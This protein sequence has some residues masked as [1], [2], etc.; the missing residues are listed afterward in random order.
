MNQANQ[1]GPNEY[2]ETKSKS[3]QERAKRRAIMQ[4]EQAKP[5]LDIVWKNNAFYFVMNQ[6][7][8]PRWF[9][10]TDDVDFESK[11]NELRQS[12]KYKAICD[13]LTHK[14]H[15]NRE[16]EKKLDELKA[17][18]DWESL[19]ERQKNRVMKKLDKLSEKAVKA[20]INEQQANSIS[21]ESELN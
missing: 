14:Y 10:I 5:E 13:D 17:E 6:G 2:S 7:K 4:Q 8:K 1:V 20:V 18:I 19:D 12:P 15:F 21:F 11:M 16:K 3:K 9:K